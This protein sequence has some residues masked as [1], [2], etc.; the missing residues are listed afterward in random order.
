MLDQ[1]RRRW[2]DVVQMLCKCFEFTG[3]VSQLS[4]YKAKGKLTLFVLQFKFELKSYNNK[5]V[6]INMIKSGNI[7]AIY[8]LLYYPWPADH[9][10]QHVQGKNIM[11]KHKSIWSFTNVRSMIMLL[12]QLRRRWASITPTSLVIAGYF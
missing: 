8:I 12:G 2:T 9:V 11:G 7:C 4:G 1:R 10:L 6:S 3:G 5:L